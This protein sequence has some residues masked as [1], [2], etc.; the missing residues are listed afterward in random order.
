MDEVVEQRALADVEELVVEQKEPDH[1]LSEHDSGTDEEFVLLPP[2]PAS[3]EA[4]ADIVDLFY[5][6]MDGPYEEDPD[7]VQLEKELFDWTDAEDDRVLVDVDPNPYPPPLPGG[8]KKKLA[9][10]PTIIADV[11]WGTLKYYAYPRCQLVAECRYAGHVKHCRLSAGTSAS[12]EKH[13]W[14]RG[15]H[16][17]Y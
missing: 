11:K 17:V 9:H 10:P 12:A 1:E 4:D 6:E 7:Q 8:K 16:W 14:R 2:S 5:D 13:P 15:G 3:S